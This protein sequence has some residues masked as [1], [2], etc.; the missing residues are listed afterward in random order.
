MAR[1]SVTLSVGSPLCPH[2]IASRKVLDFFNPGLFKESLFTRWSTTLSSNVTLPHVIDFRGPCVVHIWSRETP[3]TGPNTT[4]NS[5]EWVVRCVVR[6]QTHDARVC[7]ARQR[8]SFSLT[9]EKQ[10]GEQGLRALDS[11]SRCEGG[12]ERAPT[13]SANSTE[14]VDLCVV[15][16]KHTTRE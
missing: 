5:T 7:R 16:S 3:K 14:W 10:C 4:R 1:H 11:R 2:G 8:K 12:A 6:L 13:K 15:P 9:L